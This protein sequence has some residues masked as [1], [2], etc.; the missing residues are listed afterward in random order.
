MLNITLKLKKLALTITATAAAAAVLVFSDSVR[1]GVRQ[2]LELCAQTVIP[3]LFLFTAA[4]LFITRSGAASVLGR[5]VS[6]VTRL[7]FGIGD[8][9]ASVMLMSAVAGY[10]VGAR[11]VDSLYTSGKI[12]RAEAL[13]ML[14][15]CVN[16]GPAFIIVA[17]GE[18]VLDSRSDGWRLLAAH[19]SATAVLAAVVRFLP[20]RLFAKAPF[21]TKSAVQ[22]MR[23]DALLSDIFVS[24]VSDAGSTM[25]SVCF[26]VVFFAG[27]GGGLSAVK[28]TFTDTLGQLLEVTSGI[29]VCTRNTLPLA[30]FLLGFG[31]LSVMFQVL[32]AA[33]NCI[34]PFWLLSVS[35]LLHG[36]LSA[37]FIA[38]A[39]VI[40]PR[41]LETGTFGVAAEKA[42]VSA[43]P[44]AAAALM[45]L[46][47]VMLVFTQNVRVKQNRELDFS[48]MIFDD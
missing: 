40:F 31:G 32:S 14:T 1:Q 11:L 42:A 7:L 23:N 39:E 47:A 5:I 22:T 8:E 21:K 9:K 4:A 48:R 19:L 36:T 45:L 10:P 27:A 33:K 24:S 38:L 6:P 13:K 3:S 16:A 34:M 28:T 15:F 44:A 37:A 18:A 26:F 43:S 25:L 46:C 29:Q 12:S 20:D 35:R 41:T 2:G 17:V 30:A